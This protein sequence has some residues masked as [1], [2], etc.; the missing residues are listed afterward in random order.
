MI[1]RMLIGFCNLSVQIKLFSLFFGILVPKIMIGLTNM[2]KGHTLTMQLGT[3]YSY[4]VFFS[5]TIIYTLYEET[6]STEQN[7]VHRS[8]NSVEIAQALS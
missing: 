7:A 6:F 2:K 4:V 3:C 8:L 1:N 5:P